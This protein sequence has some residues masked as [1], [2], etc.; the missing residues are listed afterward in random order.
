MELIFVAERDC[1]LKTLLTENRLS[2]RY[3]NKLLSKKSNIFING[4]VYLYS[5]NLKKGDNVKIIQ[6]EQTNIVPAFGD[7]DIVYENDLFLVINKPS[8]IAVIPTAM[9]YKSSLSNR[10]LYYFNQKGLDIGI[11]VVNRLDKDTS[12]LV[13]FAKSN[14]I[15][16]LFADTKIIKKYRCYVRGILKEKI[17]IITSKIA[18]SKD[19]IKREI[20]E[21]GQDAIT[22][23]K[24][25]E[26]DTINNKSLV[27]LQ[28]ETGRTHQ[29]RVHLKS[30]GHEIIGDRLYGESGDFYLCSYYLSFKFPLDEKEYVFEI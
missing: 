17:G 3:I 8:G 5:Y 14:Y 25:I 26:E 9:H 11:H 29:I 18:K 12:G 6:K 1:D 2:K 23:Y 4:Q 10:V 16:S 13:I 7:L 15:H 22:R 28:L 24:V 19:G 27:E 21:N 20:S 30:I